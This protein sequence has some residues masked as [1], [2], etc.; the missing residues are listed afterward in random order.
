MRVND[1][2]TELIYLLRYKAFYMMEVSMQKS[3]TLYTP[4]KEPILLDNF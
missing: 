1:K 2:N 4:L 3:M